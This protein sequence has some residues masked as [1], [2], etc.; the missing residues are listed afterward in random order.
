LI[1]DCFLSNMNKDLFIKHI[2]WLFR[3]YDAQFRLALK[4]VKEE[5]VHDLRVMIKR[6]TTLFLFL[7]E[8]DIYKKRST[9]FFKRLRVFFRSAG[10]LRDIQVIKALIGSYKIRIKYDI[11]EYEYYLAGKEIS[12]KNTFFHSSEK[13]PKL[14]Q[15]EVKN[16]IIGSVRKFS[17]ENLAQ[18]SFLFMIKRLNRIDEYLK[19]TSTSKYL[20]KIRQTLKQLRYFIEIFHAGA[21]MSLIEES[22]YNEIKEIENIIGGWNDRSILIEDIKNYKTFNEKLGSRSIWPELNTLEQLIKTDRKEM[23]KDIKPRLLK[24][25]YNLKYSIL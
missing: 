19:S 5:P 3:E 15:T 22:D 2:R 14:M 1:C 21:D 24:F 9:D 18:K 4:G 8:A 6:L 25:I 7:D 13:Y 20:H 10:Y 12:A 11:S 16:A 17:D 23:V